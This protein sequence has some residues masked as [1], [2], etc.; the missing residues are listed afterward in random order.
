E[1]L[2]LTLEA[3]ADDVWILTDSKNSIHYLRNWPN[4]LDKLR[5]DI[6]LK[7]AALT[8]GGTVC[9]QWIPSHVGVYG[10]EVADLLVGE[11]SELPTT[12][13]TELRTSEVHSLFLANVKIPLGGPRLNMLGMSL[14]SLDCP[15]SASVQD[16]LSPLYLDLGLVTLRV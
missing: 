16:L 6:I 8:Q 14:S 4:I 7:L 11:G 10:N 1:A 5:Q 2:N 3:D 15:C 12:P 9:L 13:S